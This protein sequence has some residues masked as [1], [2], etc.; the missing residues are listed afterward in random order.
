MRFWIASAAGLALMLVVMAWGFSQWN[1]RY[2]TDYI[3]DRLELLAELR[4][5]AVEEYF[6]TAQA[7]L[8]FWSKN[9]RLLET[10]RQ[11]ND[12]WQASEAHDIAEINRRYAVDN[13]NPAGFLL[14]LDDAGDGS[15]YSELHARL[16]PVARLFVTQRGYYDFFLIGPDGDIYYSVE[17]EADFASNLES[18]PWKD[19]GLAEVFS[20]A[21]KG[22]SGKIIAVSDMREYGPSDGAPAIFAATALHDDAGVFLGVLALQLPTDRI[23]GIMAYTAGMGDTGE[24]YLV[25]EDLLMRSDSRFSE[26]STILSQSVETP[27]VARALAGEQGRE[28]ITD[29]RGEEVLSGFVPLAVGNNRWAVMAEMDKAE[30]VEFAAGQQP[31]LGGVL[32]LIYGLSL[33]TVW[34]WR[35][36]R[37]PED[38]QGLPGIDLPDSEASAGLG[39]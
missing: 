8:R 17:K 36:R 10:Q 32:A 16:H 37:L 12:V 19:T 28:V 2:Y 29:Y 9:D 25:G 3:G 11:L 7:E 20:A 6:A 4:R 5:G 39:S 21:R 34:Y 1:L 24:T 14:N 30:I 15:D 38:S 31:P 27:A 22:R 23:V 13:P 35:G 26:Q 18:G 33:W